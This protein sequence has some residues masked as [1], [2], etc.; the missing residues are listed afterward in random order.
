MFSQSRIARK[1][2]RRDKPHCITYP[3]L[4]YVARVRS[5]SFTSILPA[6][7]FAIHDTG[8][9]GRCADPR[10]SVTVWRR[11]STSEGRSSAAISCCGVAGAPEEIR[12]SDP[13]IVVWSSVK[14]GRAAFNRPLVI[15]PASA[16]A[17][18][19]ASRERICPISPYRRVF[20]ACSSSGRN[21]SN[22]HPATR[23]FGYGLE[24]PWGH[25]LGQRGSSR[26][27]ANHDWSRQE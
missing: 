19:P 22:S 10:L 3:R 14:G 16:A 8:H 25:L 15:R 13:Q 12:T 17:S 1:I 18:W 27:G 11:A 5:A 6:A 9:A 4:R 7:L 26:C 2:F 24:V 23:G 21:S 20:R